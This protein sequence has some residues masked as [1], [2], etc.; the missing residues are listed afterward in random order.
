MNETPGGEVPP[1]NYVRK[2][3]VTMLS[4]ASKSINW[5]KNTQAA[6]EARVRRSLAR[7]GLK[8]HR[9]PSTSRWHHEVGDHY[10]ADA[11]T[12]FILDKHVDLEE[13]ARDL[14]VLATGEVI[15]E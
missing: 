6:V 9:C 14:G 10:V 5:R 4:I 8:L 7:E 3:I 12:R 11:A 15:V 2:G 1:G 13:L